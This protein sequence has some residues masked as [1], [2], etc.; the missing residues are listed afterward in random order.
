MISSAKKQVLVTGSGGL[1]GSSLCKVLLN[2]GY[3][4]KGFDLN[5]TG[6][7]YGDIRNR[8]AVLKAVEGCAG[9]VHLAAVSRVI[10]G[11]QFPELCRDINVGGMQ[12]LLSAIG[13]QQESPWLIFASSRE[14]YGNAEPLPVKESWPLQP[15]NTYGETKLVS[16]E[17]ILQQSKNEGLRAVILRFSNVFGGLNDYEDRVIPAFVNAALH[18]SPLRVDG[19]ASTFDFTFLEDV[20]E[21]IVR[22]CSLLESGKT[23][24]SP[25]H[26]VSG[27]PTTLGELAETILEITGSNS[28]IEIT[29]SRNYDVGKFYGDPDE[30]FD[31]LGWRHTTPLKTGLL[32]LAEMLPGTRLRPGRPTYLPENSVKPITLNQV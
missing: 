7:G 28:P 10:Y 5:A 22:C 23:L 14:V 26:L 6:D 11:E 30:A 19:E 4:V 20:V 29:P 8:E 15:I 21:G 17:M 24:P 2:N 18:N 1:I 3:K 9:V 13:K 32:R 27:V 16:E 31:A 12:N 25:V